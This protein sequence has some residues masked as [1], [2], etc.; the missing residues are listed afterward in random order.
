MAPNVP[1]E[2]PGLTF[3]Q[4]MLSF[5]SI[6]TNT[7]ST[8]LLFSGLIKAFAPRP[9]SEKYW[10]LNVARDRPQDSWWKRTKDKLTGAKKSPL[11]DYD[12]PGELDN[13]KAIEKLT[14]WTEEWIEAQHSLIEGCSAAIQKRLNARNRN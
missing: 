6:A 2:K 13:V 4:A 9:G 10:R 3:Y 1:I 5:A 14:Q 8:H 12:S 7:E 11:K